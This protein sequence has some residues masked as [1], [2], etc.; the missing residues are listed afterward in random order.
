MVG[1][2]LIAVCGDSYTRVARCGGHNFLHE[3]GL[4]GEVSFDIAFTADILVVS[5]QHKHF[6]PCGARL[7]VICAASGSAV[8]FGRMIT[9]GI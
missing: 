1:D 2:K 3:R 5:A 9:R 7:S 8:A 4:P 6:H